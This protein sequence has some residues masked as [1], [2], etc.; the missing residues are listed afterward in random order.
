MVA[1]SGFR[2]SHWAFFW[3]LPIVLAFKKG[4]S[5][6][7]KRALIFAFLATSNPSGPLSRATFTIPPEPASAFYVL[8]QLHSTSQYL[9]VHHPTSFPAS[10]LLP[11]VGFTSEEPYSKNNVETE[12]PHPSPHAR[13][14]PGRIL[15]CLSPPSNRFASLSSNSSTFHPSHSS[16]RTTFSTLLYR[17]H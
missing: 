15:A 7:K 2:R 16:P 4:R 10:P 17:A 11:P 3:K 12:I 13:P 1:V 8:Y 9:T 6:P 14:R 5:F